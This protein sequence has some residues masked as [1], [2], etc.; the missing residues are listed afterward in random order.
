MIFIYYGNIGRFEGIDKDT[1]VVRFSSKKLTEMGFTFKYS[2]EDMFREAIE[3]CREKGLLP[4]STR[5]CEVEENKG[6]QQL[7]ISKEIIAN[8]EVNGVH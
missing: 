7:P 2:L 1:P 6:K 3:T 4:Y 5:S 8:G